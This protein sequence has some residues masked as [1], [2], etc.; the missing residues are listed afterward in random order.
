[1]PKGGQIKGPCPYKRPR[2]IRRHRYTF[3]L[4]V[5]DTLYKMIIGNP[6][7]MKSELID[8]TVN[9]VSA[10]IVDQIIQRDLLA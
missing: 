5:I 2:P 1:M 7:R 10:T 4:V 3:C 8:M 9:E 6:A